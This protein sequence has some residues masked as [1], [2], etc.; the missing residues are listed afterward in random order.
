[1]NVLVLLVHWFSL[2]KYDLLLVCLYTSLRAAQDFE[3]SHFANLNYC[4]YIAC[5]IVPERKQ[6]QNR[7]I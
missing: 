7:G 1:M 2:G 3:G 6:F 5:Q 4:T